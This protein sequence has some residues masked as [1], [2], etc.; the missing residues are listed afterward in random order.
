MEG[1]GKGMMAGIL[2][3]AVARMDPDDKTNGNIKWNFTKFLFDREGNL[4]KRFEPTC[5]V[6]E[7]RKESEALL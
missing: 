5:P 6:K 3:K 2:K 4:V 1:F 7:V